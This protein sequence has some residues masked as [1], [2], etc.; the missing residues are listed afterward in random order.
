MSGTELWIPVVSVSGGMREL[1]TTKNTTDSR[2]CFAFRDAISRFFF[3]WIAADIN[4]SFTWIDGTHFSR[5]SPSPTFPD[6]KTGGSTGKTGT[7]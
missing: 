6:T 4:I 7:P 5:S 2:S 3:S 1:E